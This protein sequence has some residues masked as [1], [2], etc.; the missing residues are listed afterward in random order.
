MGISPAKPRRVLKS[1]RTE[2]WLLACGLITVVVTVMASPLLM[3]RLPSEEGLPW[4]HLADIGQAYGGA[5]ALLSAAALCGIVASLLYQRRQVRQQ[6]AEMDRQQHL[7]LMGMVLENPELVE[8]LDARI[9]DSPHV[10]K[11]LF[12]NSM[13]MYWLTLW[14]LREIDDFELRNMAADMFR[15]DIT[16]R[17]W[18]RVGAV[19]IGTNGRPERRRFVSIVIEELAKARMRPAVSPSIERTGSTHSAPMSHRRDVAI[20]VLAAAFAGLSAVAV[21]RVKAGGD[22]RI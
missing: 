8:V 18:S 22:D 19:W 13:M 14:E 9:A 2:N 10:K 1:E 3:I 12:A 15:S 16:R 11:E 20:I 17:W 6:L 4:R 5:S 21:H 7:E